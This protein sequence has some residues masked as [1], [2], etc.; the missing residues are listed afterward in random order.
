MTGT[1]L[2]IESVLAWTQRSPHD[3]DQDPRG[4][5]T[6]VI[7]ELEVLPS[8]GKRDEVRADVTFCVVRLTGRGDGEGE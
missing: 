8:R 5:R 2:A 6:L 7:D 3:P 1:S 4:G